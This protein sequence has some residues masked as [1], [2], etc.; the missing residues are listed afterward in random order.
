MNCKSTWRKRVGAAPPPTDQISEGAPL[1]YMGANGIAAASEQLMQQVHGSTAPRLC[2]GSE[3]GLA[4][5]HL[6]PPASSSRGVIFHLFKRPDCVQ[7]NKAQPHGIRLVVALRSSPPAHETMNY[8][9][10]PT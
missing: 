3:R 9:P 8:S 10:H 2:T 4:L 6:A 1:W 7:C 5:G